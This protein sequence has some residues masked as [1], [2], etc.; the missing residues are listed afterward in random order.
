MRRVVKVWCSMR[1]RGVKLDDLRRLTR[2]VGV[3]GDIFFTLCCSFLL[4]P[5]MT[6]PRGP[7]VVGVAQSNPNLRWSV[8]TALRYI[9]MLLGALSPRTMYSQIA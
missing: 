5:L 1:Q 7:N 4:R 2:I 6:W 9:W 8:R 3:M